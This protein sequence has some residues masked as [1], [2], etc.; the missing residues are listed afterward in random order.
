MDSNIFNLLDD[1]AEM[2]RSIQQRIKSVEKGTLEKDRSEIRSKSII[3]K[4]NKIQKYGKQRDFIEAA[5]ADKK[6]RKHLLRVQ[7][8]NLY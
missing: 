5:K 2:P 1:D 7:S 3:G 6:K 4:K 8:K